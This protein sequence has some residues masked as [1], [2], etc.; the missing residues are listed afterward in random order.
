MAQIG[1][2]WQQAATRLGRLQQTH[3][4][5]QPEFE[6]QLLLSHVIHKDR[7]WLFAWPEKQVSD[8][9]HLVYQEL[10]HRRSKG[11]PIAYITGQKEFWSLPLTV[12]PATLI[13]RP[14]TELLV[15]HVLEMTSKEDRQILDLGTGT[16]AIALALASERPN[17][18]IMAIDNSQAAL[19]IAKG[20]R[21]HLALNNI[22]FQ[23]SH[24]FRELTSE[25]RFDVI[26]SNPPY[27]PESD[28][29]LT[30]GD[31]AFEP[32][33]ALTAGPDGMNA[34]REIIRDSVQFIQDDGLL[35]LE[36]GYDQALATRSLL[37]DAGYAKIQS[38]QDLAQLDRITSGYWL[39]G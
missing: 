9:D 38:H 25:Q 35:I 37:Q 8:A 13:P 33:G 17:W 27:I 3:K 5:I 19:E 28:R 36:H 24:W 26:L 29:H 20:N 34:L 22:H 10:I 16:G 18:Q 4:D 2:V 30:E 39:S 15:E 11:E 6:A 23:K 14:E 31:V 7:S 12:S 1:E 21:D 32:R